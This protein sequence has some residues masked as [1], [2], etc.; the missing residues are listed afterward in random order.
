MRSSSSCNAA[1]VIGSS[2]AN[3]SSISSRSGSAGQRARHPDP[4]LLAAGKLVRVFSAIGLAGRGAADRSNSS[5]RSRDARPRPAQ[6][7]RHGRDVVLRPANAETGRP[8]GSRSRCG[9]AAPPAALPHI[10]AADPDRAGIERH[11]PV[12]HAQC[13]R[14]AAAGGPEQHAERALRHASATDRRR[15]GGRHSSCV[16]CSISIIGANRRRQ[17]A[18]SAI[19]SRKS[20]ASASAIVG[21]RAE[22]DQIGGVLAEPLK[23]EACRDRRRRSAPRQ[24]PARSPAR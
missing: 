10:L 20:A 22:Q 23:H 17:H 3:G 6:Q 21:K 5:T 2:A 11:E 14:F 18:R 19:C 13:R 7:A 9:G 15:R 4:L 12:D 8:T 16:T 24:P 1:R